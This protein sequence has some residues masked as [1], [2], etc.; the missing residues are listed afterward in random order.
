MAT[1]VDLDPK[2]VDEAVAVGGYRTKFCAFTFEKGRRRGEWME[3]KWRV[4]FW[5][6]AARELKMSLDEAYDDDDAE[7]RAESLMRDEAVR[8]AT[9]TDRRYEWAGG[10]VYRD[11]WDERANTMHDLAKA[12]K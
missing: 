3:E 7:V 12:M 10:R 5:E 8:I 4:P 1:N 2:V 6:R 9:G 11:L